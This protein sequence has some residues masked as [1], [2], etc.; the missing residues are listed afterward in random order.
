ML[1]RLG[2]R[3]RSEFASRYN[4]APGTKIPA[5]RKAPKTGSCELAELRWGL[6]PAWTKGEASGAGLVNAR[7]ESLAGKPSFREAF[8]ERRCLL[9]ASG[10]YEWKA[11]KRAPQPWLFRRRDERPF[12]LAGL[13]ESWC[14]PDGSS[15]E[16]CAVI[17]TGPNALMQPVHHRMPAMLPVEAGSL[18]LNPSTKESDLLA[19]LSSPF[20][21]DEMTACAVSTR[22]NSVAHDDEACLRPAD[23]TAADDQQLFAL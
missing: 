11:A 3:A 10:F 6:V 13:W 4:I 9:P 15:V 21:A 23:T 14:S 2:L 18:W 12:F 20:P 22:V 5:V 7:A 8:R 1:E 19:M 17:T 16:T